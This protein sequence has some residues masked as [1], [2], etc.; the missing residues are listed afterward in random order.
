[1]GSAC[2]LECE[3][4]LS[5]DLVFITETVQ[6]HMLDA[7]IQVKRMLGGLMGWLDRRSQGEA[8]QI[9]KPCTETRRRNTR[10]V[11]VIGIAP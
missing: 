1:M 5:C 2:E 11:T 10:P 6:K 7:V 9:A 8:E 4:I 3:T